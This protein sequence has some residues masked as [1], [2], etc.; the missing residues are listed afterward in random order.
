MTARSFTIKTDNPTTMSEDDVR[1]ELAALAAEALAAHCGRAQ[2]SITEAA[3][4]RGVFRGARGG[5][6]CCAQGGR[7]HCSRE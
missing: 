2:R 3:A 7:A 5:V 1:R 6:A 4:V